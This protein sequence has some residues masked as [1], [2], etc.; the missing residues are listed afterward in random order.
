MVETGPRTIVFQSETPCDISNF[1]CINGYTRTTV[2]EIA[3]TVAE[4]L[5]APLPERRGQIIAGRVLDIDYGQK[6]SNIAALL[7]ARDLRIHS[8]NAQPDAFVNQDLHLEKYKLSW[9]WKE[10]YFVP[11]VVKGTGTFSYAYPTVAS[12]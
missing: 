5:D 1:F 4:T 11:D 9:R 2:Y 6:G 12:D 10:T 3:Q 7:S 8:S